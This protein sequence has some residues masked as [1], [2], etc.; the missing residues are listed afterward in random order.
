MLQQ[1]DFIIL[2]CTNKN[3]F[4]VQKAK[5]RNEIELTKKDVNSYLLAHFNKANVVS[6]Y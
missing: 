4:N 5:W 2:D 6:G 1:G 3:V